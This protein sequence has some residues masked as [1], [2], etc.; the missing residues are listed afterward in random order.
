MAAKQV[1]KGKVE[2]NKFFFYG[3]IAMIILLL[4]K[5]LRWGGM[6]SVRR[7]CG[8]NGLSRRSHKAS[9]TAGNNMKNQDH[10]SSNTPLAIDYGGISFKNLVIVSRLRELGFGIGMTHMKLPCEVC[11]ETEWVK[12][13]T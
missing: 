4:L 2:E 12:L 1:R 13:E 3:R 9:T 6:Y 11:N 8:V 5:H 7:G 10:I